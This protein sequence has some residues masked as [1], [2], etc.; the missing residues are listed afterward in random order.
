MERLKLRALQ[1]PTSNNLNNDHR[2]PPA[3]RRQLSFLA[4]PNSLFLSPSLCALRSAL[5]VAY[6]A[7]F[8]LRS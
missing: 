1:F 7:T 4:C 3:T 5:C 8:E 2:R 6:L